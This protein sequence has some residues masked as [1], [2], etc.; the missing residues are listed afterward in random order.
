MSDELITVDSFPQ[1]PCRYLVELVLDLTS[2]FIRVCSIRCWINAI[3][4]HKVLVH[5]DGRVR[6]WSESCEPCLVN[7]LHFV[8]VRIG[9]LQS[10]LLHLLHSSFIGS[11]H[12][13]SEVHQIHPAFVRCIRLR[14]VTCSVELE[15]TLKLRLITV[16]G[17]EVFSASQIE[18]AVEETVSNV[19]FD[20]G[21]WNSLRSSRL[22]HFTA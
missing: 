16:E 6:Y 9:A 2:T 8:H 10:I 12:A 17:L 7:A 22:S 14:L 18:V 13:L 4:V 5:R 15:R 1:P 21:L 3:R 19:R 11:F 20:D